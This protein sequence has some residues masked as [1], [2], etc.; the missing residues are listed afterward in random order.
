V[1]SVNLVGRLVG[2]PAVRSVLTGE[3]EC[4]M[5]VAI[6]RVGVGGMPEPGV[7]YVDVV[8]AGLR[9]RGLGDVHGGM[10]IAVSGRL[11]LEEWVDPDGE[12]R[13]R[14]EVVADQLEVLDPPP[15]PSRAADP[16]PR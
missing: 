13:T 2:A 1:N 9:A 10:R 3:V 5:R 16:E 4:T 14:H 15:G 6:P 7:V 11:E 12:R 8:A